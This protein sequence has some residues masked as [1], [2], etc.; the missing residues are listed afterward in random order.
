VAIVRESTEFCI[1]AIRDGKYIF[2]V[3]TQKG[4]PDEKSID[5][6]LKRVSLHNDKH[7]LVEKLSRGMQQKLNIAIA[8]LCKAKLI[9]L[10]EPTLGLDII[11]NHEIVKL[12]QEIKLQENSILVASHDM[13]LIE[14]IVDRVVLIKNGGML[15]ATDT[16]FKAVFT[17]R[18]W[19]WSKISKLRLATNNRC[20][21][22]QYGVL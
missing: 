21:H 1:G 7:T 9:I 15:V 6:M 16:S 3:T 22:K 10:D 5:E 12:L 2:L 11:A 17:S 8:L 14:S 20:Y 4:K 13:S 19:M 18:L